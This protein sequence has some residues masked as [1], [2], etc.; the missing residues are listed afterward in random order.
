M[1]GPETYWF[2]TVCADDDFRLAKIKASEMVAYPISIGETAIIGDDYYT[3]CYDKVFDLY[4]KK[5]PFKASD[6]DRAKE[7]I[8]L[9]NPSPP[10]I[11]KLK[12][13]F[14]RD[15]EESEAKKKKEEKMTSKII[16]LTPKH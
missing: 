5:T 3:C 2:E 7:D 16:A 12:V 8:P 6:K 14:S 11:P 4:F 15:R 13:A 1:E 9:K 10:K